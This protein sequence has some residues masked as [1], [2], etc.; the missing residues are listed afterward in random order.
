MVKTYINTPTYAGD[1]VG[2][3]VDNIRY[4]DI[5]VSGSV[6]GLQNLFAGLGNGFTAFFRRRFFIRYTDS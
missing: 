6:F 5:A 2:T 4:I 1:G 3:L